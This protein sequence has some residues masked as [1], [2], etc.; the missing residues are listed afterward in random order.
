MGD[1]MNTRKGLCYFI[2]ISSSQLIHM[3]A[4][5]Q[6]ERTFNLTYCLETCTADIVFCK[7]IVFVTDY[8]K[9]RVSRLT[10]DFTH[11]HSSYM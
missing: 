8:K 5:D 1:E 11:G 3:S 10:T 7:L 4:D 6:I 9:T 2:I